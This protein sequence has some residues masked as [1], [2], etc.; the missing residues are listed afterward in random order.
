MKATKILSA[1]KMIHSTART[2]LFPNL[3]INNGLSVFFQ[4][5]AMS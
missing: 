1:I 2:Q 5:K 4:S 3:E